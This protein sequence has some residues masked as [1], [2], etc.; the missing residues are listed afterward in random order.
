MSKFEPKCLRVTGKIAEAWHILCED[1]SRYVAKI[2]IYM[3]RFR[4][5]NVAVSRMENRILV[6]IGLVL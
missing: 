1:G 2:C 4:S 6:G 5:D 3:G